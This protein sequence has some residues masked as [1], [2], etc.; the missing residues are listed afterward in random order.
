[1]KVDAVFE[2][3][4]VRGIGLV[5]AVCCLEQYGYSWEKLAGT[6]AGSIMAALLA[7]GYTGEELKDIIMNL[8]YQLFLAKDP[9]QALPLI[10]GALG[11]LTV[12]GVYSGDYIETWLEKLLIAKGKTKF[13]HVY[14]NGTSQLKII[15]SDITTRDLLILPD[16]LPKY[17]I[18]PLEFSIA[19]AVRMSSSIPFYFKPVILKHKHGQNYIVDGGIL[20]NYP[21]WIFDVEGIPRW[22]TFGFKFSD[23][24]VSY[25]ASGKRDI[26]SYSL[27]IIGTML[28]RN[29]LKII[30]DKDYIRTVPIPTGTI[31]ATHFNITSAESLKLFSAGYQAAEQFLNTWD[32]E[33][34]VTI[35]R[36]E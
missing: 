6:S 23:N 22:P 32:F 30:K 19:K 3:G 1:M 27:D 26:V 14:Q 35:Y 8:D 16:D 11:L 18:D 29:E 5:G 4:G 34:Y 33:K 25:T 7:V 2:G 21:V 10:G 15:S 24:F 13:K 9:L 31:G 36:R 12:K 28:D 17:G 20:S